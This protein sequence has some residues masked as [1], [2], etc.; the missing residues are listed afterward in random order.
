MRKI[1]L[2]FLISILLVGCAS[3]TPIS[4][5]VPV[6]SASDTPA[7]TV[8]PVS[9][10]TASE[11]PVSTI[12][13]SE[14]PISTVTPSETP[15]PENSTF[16]IH[17][18]DV[19][20]ADAAL[21]ECDGRYM[22]ID[23]GNKG[24]SSKIYSVLKKAGAN[25]LDIVVG[26]HPHED[27]IGGIPG[28]FNFSTALLTISPVLSYDSDAFNDFKR[29]AEKNGGGLIVPKIG[30]TYKLGSADIE[31]LGLNASDEPNNSSIVLRIT[32]GN[33]AFLFTGDAER[34]AEQAVLNSG[35]D[36]SADVLKVGHHGSDTSTTYP[37]LREVMPEYAVI[38]VGMDNMYGHPTDN[39]LSKLRDADVTV[40]RTDLNGDIYMTSDGTTITITTDKNVSADNVTPTTS[41]IVDKPNN[42]P[43]AG[44]V[45]NTNTGKFHRPSCSSVEKIKAK[46]R[47]DFNGTSEEAKSQGYTPCKICNP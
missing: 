11:I 29:Y 19:G 30:D 16:S 12:T 45:L 1:L 31:I 17:F 23:G 41:N 46:N 26:T 6:V 7:P 32:Y 25:N 28:A 36:I 10:V 14:T 22:L 38:G 2:L 34:D 5:A 13:P 37:F 24:D 21:V 8:T 39:T 40:Y 27:H 33:T 42:E 35:A 15:T 18:I 44:Y 20:Q 3:V 43:Q 4:E 47:E 9:T